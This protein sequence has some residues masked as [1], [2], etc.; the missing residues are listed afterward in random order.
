MLA[1]DLGKGCEKD[2]ADDDADDDNDDNDDEDI[3]INQCDYWQNTIHEYT[4]KEV[5]IL[6]VGGDK[7]TKVDQ[8]MLK[9]VFLFL[10]RMADKAD[11][12]IGIFTSNLAESWMNIRC[13]F[14]G[15]K[16]RNR[17]PGLIFL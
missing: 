9:D 17:F 8:Q 13:K 14:D 15:G 4:E 1:N 6:R 5:E 7:N 16:M 12:L 2:V 3:I 10:N 11:R